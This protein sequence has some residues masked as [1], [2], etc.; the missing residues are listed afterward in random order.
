[1]KPLGYPKKGGKV[2]PNME[3]VSHR[4][5]RLLRLLSE[6]KE[7]PGQSAQDLAEQFGTSKRNLF[8]DIKLLQD[9]GFTIESE[10][11]YSL[12]G[13]PPEFASMGEGP[14]QQGLHPWELPGAAP[15]RLELRIEPGLARALHHQPLHPT[16]K[17]VGNRL[18]LIANPDRVVD[19]LMSI[20]G[21]ELLE[22]SWLRGS[23]AR[24]AQELLKTYG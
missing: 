6:I 22:P 8:R 17:I 3:D 2:C 19:W 12:A 18:S 20:Q 13:S 9:S 1:M 7:K 15:V 16:Q 11:G 14:L 21:A 23:L 5:Q 24:R 10:G 4:F